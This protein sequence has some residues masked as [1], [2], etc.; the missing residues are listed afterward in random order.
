MTRLRGRAPRG[1]RLRAGVP[2]GHWKTTT[3]VA[4]LRLTGL[5]APMV[6]D[7]PMDRMAFLAYAQHIL[8]PTLSKDDIVIMD[9]LPAHKGD[10]IRLIIER[11]GA[12]L[13]FLPPYSPDF[14]PIENAFAKLKALLRKAAERTVEGL[15]RTIG[16]LLD[17]FSPQECANYF[18]A[19]GYDPD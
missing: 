16:T 4:G 17:Q 6:L 11:T 9:N 13:V 19:A 1:E 5:T 8:A 7:G 15:W 14:N 18:A 3:F 12:K 10:E 2:H